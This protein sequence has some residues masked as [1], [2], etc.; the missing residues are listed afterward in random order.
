[1]TLIEKINTS[2]K[3]AIK[4]KDEARKRTFRAVKAKLTNMSKT[5]T[6]RPGGDL[7]ESSQV[8]PI[9]RK[10]IKERKDSYETYAYQGRMDLAD[11]EDD[12]IKI[13]EELLP[14]QMSEEDII[15]TISTLINSDFPDATKRNMG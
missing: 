11:I 5:I 7:V 9:L 6:P 14:Q 10:M 15:N 13:I 12:E 2:L 1:M 8:I 4:N 3:E